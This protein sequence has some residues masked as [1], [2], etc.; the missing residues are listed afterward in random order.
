MKST[1]VDSDGTVRCPVCRATQFAVKRTA[2]AKVLGGLTVGI[3]A[4]AAPKRAH[5][6]GCGEDLK[7]AAT[8]PSAALS[9]P[10]ADQAVGSGDAAKVAD[11]LEQL[12]AQ[13]TADDARD[14][15]FRRWR[16]EQDAADEAAGREKMGMMAASSLHALQIKDIGERKRA[17]AALEREK[18]AAAKAADFAARRYGTAPPQTSDGSPS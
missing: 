6:M 5:C 10:T 2:K 12:R 18:K 4:L 8:P 3:G 13:V 7:M 15:N 11:P 14:M 17:L 1:V 9:M 16:K